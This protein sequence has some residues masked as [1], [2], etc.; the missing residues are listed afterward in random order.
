MTEAAKIERVVAKVFIRGKIEDVWREITKTD[1]PQGCMFNSQLHTDGLRPGGQIR[2]RTP[3]GKFTG[4]V[5]EVLEFDPPRRF[6]HTMKFTQYP[7]PLCK[8][9]YELR[10]VEGGVEF[11][12]TADEI[13]SGTKTA[14][15]MK[16]G[17]DMIAKTLKAIV[18][19]GKPPLGVRMLFTLFKV[20]EPFSP[21]STR[22]EN[23]PLD[24]P[25]R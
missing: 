22:T 19:T 5:G 21:K 17:A 15:E 2:M 13:P 14:K 25:I 20:M 3:N 7:D 9:T 4:V 16:R 1:A 8:V 12:L 18:E 23:W 10:Q 24:R 11:T 6:S